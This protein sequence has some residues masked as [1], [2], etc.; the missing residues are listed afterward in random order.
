M[1][2]KIHPHKSRIIPLYR[3]VDFVGFRNFYN[4]KLLRKRNI[5]GM[6][7]KIELYRKGI[8]SFETIFNSY[9][10]WFAYAIWADTYNLRNR[11]K[12]EI[13]DL[14]IDKI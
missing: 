3:G 8:I 9:H 14:L 2:I 6:R 10:G 1:K 11:I 4:F 13:I 5:K 12:M 7:R